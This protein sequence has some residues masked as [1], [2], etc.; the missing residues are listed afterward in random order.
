GMAILDSST[1]EI[2]KSMFALN[3]E[4]GMVAA[5]QGATVRVRGTTIEKNGG[6]GALLVSAV[7]GSITE[8]Q[9]LEN[10]AEGVGL[11]GDSAGDPQPTVNSNNIYMNGT[12]AAAHQLVTTATASVLAAACPC[13]GTPATS[14]TYQAPTG[15]T[16]HRAHLVFPKR[17]DYANAA[18]FDGDDRLIV[19][20]NKSFDGWVPLPWG[21]TTLK[22]GVYNPATGSK[23][24]TV[25]V[26]E[27]EILTSSGEVDVVAFT[28]AGTVDFRRNYLGTFPNVLGRTRLARSE[29]LDVQGFVGAAYDDTWKT[30]PYLAGSLASGV[31]SGTV[32][33]TGDIS[34][35]AGQKITVA[36]GTKVLFANHDQNGDGAGDFSITA[37][38]RLEV[39]GT[40]DLGRVLFAGYGSASGDRDV[41]ESIVLAGNGDTTGAGG[42]GGTGSGGSSGSDSSIR[43]A[44]VRH[45][46]DGMV[47]SDS[48]RLVE[49]LI[50]GG[51]GN[52]I[53]LG[54][55]AASLE[56]VQV[57][58]AGG[59]GIVLANPAGASLL[60]ITSA[61]NAGDGVLVEGSAGDGTTA[62]PI[63]PPAPATLASPATV[64]QHL[65]TRNNGGTGIRIDSGAAPQIVDAVVRENASHGVLVVGA[66]PRIEHSL[67][68]FNGGSGIWIEGSG[69][70]IVERNIVKYN[71]D[72]GISIWSSPAGT[73]TPVVHYSNVFGN[74]VAGATKVLRVDTAP[75]LTAT[76]PG[77][78]PPPAPTS[79]ASA[80][81]WTPSEDGRTIRRAF[82]RYREADST[83]TDYGL[84]SAALADG[85]GNT[86]ATYSKNF[87]GWLYLP[88]GT[89]SL[90]VRLVNNDRSE[91]PTAPDQTIAVDTIECLLQ[92]PPATH[93][94]VAGIDSGMI[95]ARYNF[96]TSIEADTASKILDIRG[97]SID[98][99]GYST[100]EYPGGIVTQI[101]PR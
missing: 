90:Q 75:T 31:W 50:E 64:V 79:A 73:P 81:Y 41:F 39:E 26:P 18:L 83:S 11:I 66:S 99:S 93:D 10:G 24:D 84:K 1:L 100:S 76:I 22:V 15:Q 98:Y 96:W 27:V 7:G 59:H 4:H 60:R 77:S 92:S 28:N 58:G 56:D 37:A 36:A 38:G 25:A 12:A 67:F 69:S 43:F 14:A 44:T 13:S 9:I 88:A 29:A 16:L 32:Y 3:A 33:V 47:V 61:D 45:G 97:E 53:R 54:P 89:T 95:D 101:G 91:N 94:L 20:I 21:T 8:S 30:G 42:D 70:P 34:I 2:S 19:L 87:E 40:A 6:A 86:I 72:A 57:I 78:T 17:S 82:L 65:T 68:A 52:G 49:V 74:A 48:S 85:Q 63:S 35:P 5:A 55:G 23:L 51:S 71:G 62:N 46:R 80:V